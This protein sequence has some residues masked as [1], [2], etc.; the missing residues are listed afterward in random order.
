MKAATRSQN[1]KSATSAPD[2]FSPDVVRA[3]RFYLDMNPPKHRL[4]SVTCGGVEH[5][6][7]K[8]AIH[9]HHFP[10]YSI[11]YVARGQGNLR[12]QGNRHEL[13]P[14]RVFSYGPDISHDL[15][16][17]PQNTLVKYFVDFAG[18]GAPKL[19]EKAGIKP[20]T[21]AQ[22]LPPDALAPLFDEL[23]AS[24]LR[25]GRDSTE[26]CTKLLEC[27]ALKIAT[28]QAPLQ[29]TDTSALA[30][31]Q[32]CR[33]YIEQNFERLRTLEQVAAEC[34][35]SVSYLCRLFRRYDDLTP[36]QY[37]LKLRMRQAAE[38]LLRPHALIKQVAEETGY[39]DPFHFSRVFRSVLGVSPAQFKKLR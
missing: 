22:M 17:D 18:T 34:H 14:G 11:E 6:S 1:A 19:L 32:E 38:K 16:S 13:H 27:L 4:L 23:I 29:D 15:T 3:R 24:G 33:S 2:F 36:Y 7:S 26:L 9:R 25:G 28:V 10:Y 31:Y 8:Y 39:A 35:S 37:L 21:A 5:C 12:L 20:G 30:F